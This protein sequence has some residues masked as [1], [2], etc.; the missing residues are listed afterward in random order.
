MIT[1]RQ[2]WVATLFVIASFIVAGRLYGSLPDPVPTHWGPEG[3]VN[4]W[5]SKPFGA[6]L[7]P[8]IGVLL[9]ALLVVLPRLSPRGFEMTPFQ[10]VYPTLVA[11]IAGLMLYVTT[12]AL[13]T[14][15]GATMPAPGRLLAGV[16]V[17]LVVI[18][19]FLGKVT[20]NF[21]IGIRTPWTL[22]SDR[23]WER[24][25]RFAG[26]VFVLGGVLLVVA[27][28]FM[29]S[30]LVLIAIVV[31]TVL[32]PAVYSYVVWHRGEANIGQEP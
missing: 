12:F 2:Y 13:A 23:V 7:G 1:F 14:A 19:N 25:H 17:F 22:A 8:L 5:T 32:S 16:G 20:Q 4:G 9:V 31:V 27:S 3:E 6:F 29:K 24:T 26:P 10:R 11:A 15:T 30:P 21:F 18:G 28:L